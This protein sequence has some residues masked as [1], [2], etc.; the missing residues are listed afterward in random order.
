M[1]RKTSFT[2]AP[3]LLVAV[4]LAIATLGA[5]APLFLAS[6]GLFGSG[7]VVGRNANRQTTPR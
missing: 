7:L 4:V 6:A 5:L 2:V 3:L 1:S